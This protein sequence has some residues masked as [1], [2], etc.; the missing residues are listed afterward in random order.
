MLQ[1]TEAVATHPEEPLGQHWWFSSLKRIL[2]RRFVEKPPFPPPLPSVPQSMEQV[3]R[4]PRS[5]WHYQGVS[6]ESPV[7]ER[8]DV[9]DLELLNGVTQGLELSHLLHKLSRRALGGCEEGRTLKAA[10]LHGQEHQH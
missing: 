3:Q 10:E 2:R 8:H 4:D 6:Q 7:D 9:T 1:L 5:A